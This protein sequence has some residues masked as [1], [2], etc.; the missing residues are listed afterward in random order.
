MRIPSVRT[1]AWKE[2]GPM[3][4][5]DIHATPELIGDSLQPSLG[6]SFYQ[7]QD[8]VTVPVHS[9]TEMRRGE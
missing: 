1:K 6:L 9:I 7:G 5:N 4:F 2:G 3:T 8:V